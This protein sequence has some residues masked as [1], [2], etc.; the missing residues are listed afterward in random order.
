[1]TPISTD[2]SAAEGGRF[3]FVLAALFGALIVAMIASMAIGPYHIALA[4]IAASIGRRLTGAPP[5]Q[6]ID[7]VVFDIRLPRLLGA[8]LV[9]AVLAAA[10][11]AF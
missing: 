8:T 4:D 9:G 6:P 2:F 1:V 10:G 11:A 3:A 5:V 7:T